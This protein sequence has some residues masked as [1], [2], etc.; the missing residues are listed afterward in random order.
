[1][2]REE[3]IELMTQTIEKMNR[4]IAENNF[5]QSNKVDD[6]LNQ[7]RPEL[8]RVNG[9]LYDTLVEYGVIR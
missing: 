5:M 8:M 3:V 2:Y 4:E 6:M 9:L 7:M 1:M